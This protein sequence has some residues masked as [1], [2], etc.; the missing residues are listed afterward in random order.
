MSERSARTWKKGLLPSQTTTPRDWRTRPDPFA[1]IWD[2][3]VVP[4]LKADETGRLEAKTIVEMLAER[5]PG[6]YGEAQLRTMQRRVRQW[7]A[8]E[9]PPKPVYFE[10]RAEP[11]REAAFDFT[12]GTEL[13]VTILGQ[14]FR[15]LLFQFLLVFSGWRW[16]GLAF[17]ET[18]EA[19][20]AGLQAALWELGGTPRVLR[21]DNLSAATH[22]L[23]RSGGRALN[24]RFSEVLEHYGAQ[25]SRISPGESH[26]NGGVEK[27]NDLLKSAVEQALIVRASRDFASPQEY[28]AFVR[29]VVDRQFNA[30]AAPA[31]AEERPLLRPLPPAPIPSYTTYRTHVRRWSTVRVRGRIYS[32]PSR[33]IGHEVE[34]RQHPDEVEVL[35]AGRVIERM[36]RLREEG[37]HRIDYRH[38]IWSLVRK[39][40]AFARYRYREDLFPS[41]VFRRAYDALRDSRGDRADVEYVRILHLAA[42]TMEATVERRLSELLERGHPFE[43]A[44]VKAATAPDRPAV[45]DIAIG[46]P[47]FGAY[48]DLLSGTMSAAGAVA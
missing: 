47:D 16:V 29:A 41:L 39:P 38:I 26:E 4:M 40:G 19:L 35:F 13:E 9:G 43:Y 11:G 44:D 46:A 48:D 17:G 15:H 22:E 45:P 27:A 24:A 36:P 28:L 23:A 32:V 6:Q 34:I 3:E 21:H 33:L 2:S 7:R 30:G 1:E 31:L 8:L 5:H 25:S 42:S 37:G 20:V 10:Q 12:H 14:A 18:F